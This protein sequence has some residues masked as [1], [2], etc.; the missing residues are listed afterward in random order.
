MRIFAKITPK[1]EFSDQAIDA[2]ID[3]LSATRAETGCHRFD[4]FTSPDRSTLY[5]DEEWANA[6]ALAF[7]HAQPYTVAV[8]K[9]YEEWLAKPPELLE[10]VPAAQSTGA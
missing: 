3:I 4:L 9:S 7:H 8:F 1:P 6:D 10:L 2:V 5:L